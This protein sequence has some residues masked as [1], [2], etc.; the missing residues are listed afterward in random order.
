MKS[1]RA[2]LDLT[3]QELREGVRAV[4]YPRIPS[5]DEAGQRRVDRATERLIETA[6]A[7]RRP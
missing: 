3:A 2:S 7:E 6:Q 5:H 1:A 4:S